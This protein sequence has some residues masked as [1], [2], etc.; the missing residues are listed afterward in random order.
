MLT[1]GAQQ[2]L[3]N[4][5]KR[6]QDRQRLSEGLRGPGG[7]S[8]AP[9]PR[10]VKQQQQQQQ[11]QK[12]QQQ[13]QQKQHEVDDSEEDS[14]GGGR[15][16]AFCKS[17]ERAQKLGVQS[18]EK[19]LQAATTGSCDGVVSKKKKQKNGGVNCL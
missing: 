3:G 13:Q 12:Q 14:E 19:L 5:I 10:P 2:R 15:G 6:S 16:S 4:K 18:R 17:R 9:A 1:V 11:Q 7:W 8:S